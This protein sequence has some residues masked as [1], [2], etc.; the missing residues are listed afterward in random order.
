MSFNPRLREGGDLTA[1]ASYVS[2]ISFNPRLR[3]GGDP[4]GGRLLTP[5][6]VSIHASAREATIKAGKGYYR[7]EVSIHA[8]AREATAGA[9]LG[10][11]KSEVSIHASAREATV[12]CR[13][14]VS[15]SLSFNPRLREGGDLRDVRPRL[16]RGC[17]N[18]RLRE[19]GDS[20]RD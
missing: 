18:P 14:G 13:V 2:R 6:G 15:V 20:R 8:S 3:E 12:A 5:L 7:F 1:V 17:F 9:R 4:R 10:S 11:I 16:V 19:G